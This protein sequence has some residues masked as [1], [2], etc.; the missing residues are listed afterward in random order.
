[1]IGCTSAGEITAE[2]GYQQ[3]DIRWALPIIW[4]SR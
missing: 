1:V 3:G 2:T 4:S